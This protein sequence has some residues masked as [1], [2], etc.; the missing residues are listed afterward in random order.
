M[1]LWLVCASVVKEP[2]A[3]VCTNRNFIPNLYGVSVALDCS[4]NIK[5]REDVII[6][7]AALS[8]A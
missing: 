8:K 1:A 2:A 3:F 5:G 6:P 7:V 4:L